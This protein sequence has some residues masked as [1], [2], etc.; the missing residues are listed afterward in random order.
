MSQKSFMTAQ[1]PTA[2]KG[3]V[4]K[5]EGQ[6]NTFQAWVDDASR[7]LTGRKGSVGQDLPAFCVDAMGRRC[8]VGKDFERARRDNAFPI[9]YFW[10]FH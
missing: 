8:H 10:E 9:R 4:P 6:F 7:V 3:Y 1:P 2:L 5:W